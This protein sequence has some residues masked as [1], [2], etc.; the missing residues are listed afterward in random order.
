MTAAALTVVIM[1]SLL[2]LSYLSRQNRD[3]VCRAG[4]SAETL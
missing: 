4:K 1:I 2:I 3:V